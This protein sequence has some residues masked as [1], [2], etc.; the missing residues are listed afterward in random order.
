MHTSG[1]IQVYIV[2]DVVNEHAM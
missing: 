2:T 1:E